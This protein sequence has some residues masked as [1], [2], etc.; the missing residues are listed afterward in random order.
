MK[1]KSGVLVVIHVIVFLVINFI[2]KYVASK[3]NLPVWLDCIGTCFTAYIYGPVC[4]GIV[5]A[6][7]SVAYGIFD[8]IALV[9]TISSILVGVLTGIMVKKGFFESFYRTCIVGAVLTSVSLIVSLPLN[10][11]F[12]HGYTSNIWGDGVCDM[13]LESGVHPFL[14]F[15]MGELVIDF[16]DKN[17]TVIFVFVVFRILNKKN[18]KK[19]EAATLI[20]A[21]LMG[22]CG[23]PSKMVYAQNTDLQRMEDGFYICSVYNE[24]NGLPGGEAN[25]VTFTIDGYVWVGTYSGLYQYDGSSFKRKESDIIKSVNCLYTDEEGRVWVGTNDRGL[26]MMVDGQVANHIDETRGLSANAISCINRD[27]KGLYYIGTKDKLNVISIVGGIEV[28]NEV[29]QVEYAYSLTSNEEG[30]TVAVTNDGNAHALWNGEYLYT[31]SSLNDKE[32]FSCAIFCDGYLYLGSYS[33]TIFQYKINKEKAEYVNRFSTKEV[34][35][36]RSIMVDEDNT[37][38]VCADNGVGFFNKAMNFVHLNT[39]SYSTSID[40]IGIDYQGNIWFT[41]SRQGLLKMSESIFANMYSKG[42][43]ETDVINCVTMWNGAF[44]IGSDNG[45]DIMTPDLML[46]T[47]NPIVE[48]LQGQRIRNLMVDSKNHLWISVSAGSGLWELSED[49][50]VNNYNEENGM[51]CNRLRSAIELEDG[52]I[53]SAHDNGITFI[54]NGQVSSTISAKDGLTAP[55]ILSLCQTKD[56]MLYAGSD[57][58]GL[59][60]IKNEKLVGKVTMNEGLSSGVILRVIEDTDGLFLVTS[61]GINYMGFDGTIKV[62]DNFP[63]SNNFDLH[64]SEDGRVWVFSSAGVFVVDYKELLSGNELSYKLLDVKSGLEGS[65]TSNSWSYITEDGLMYIPCDN[66]CYIVNTTNYMLKNVSYRMSVDYAYADE[67]R[68]DITDNR[69]IPCDGDTT[70]LTLH[71]M[72]P[73]YTTSEVYIGYQLMGFDNKETV[74]PLKELGEIKYVNLPSGTYNFVLNLYGENNLKLLEQV[75]YKVQKEMRIFDYTWFKAYFIVI[76]GFMMAW[77]TWIYVKRYNNQL[78]AK[79]REKLEQMENNARISNETIITIAKTVD[80]KDPRTSKHSER[81]AEYSA[82]IARELGWSEEECENIYKTGLL[83]DIGKIGIPDAVLNKPG[84]LTDEE[85]AIMKTHVDRG[86]EILKGFTIVKNVD[87]GTRFHH[88]RYDG[89]GYPRGLKAEEIPIQ[90]RIIGIVDAFDAMTSNRVYRQKLELS[91]VLEEMKR[92]AGT[93][94]D[95]ELT[96]VFLKLIDEGKIDVEVLY[97]HE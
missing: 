5:G 49:G 65:I 82:A 81:V 78:L 95:P 2:G 68:I 96:Q 14:S 43:Y 63:Y 90:A 32:G 9:Y 92:C 59:M 53:A 31:F 83:H 39:G 16:V 19:L 20:I 41:S 40:N 38:W 57:G 25:D 71:A 55:M 74:V 62:L 76:C 70:N 47:N 37:M 69:T 36:I 29:E 6:G 17:L 21:L 4:G 56:G 66:G 15:L 73:N 45:L 18:T 26:V 35:N 50:T 28:T 94:F 87:L 72:V 58:G 88:E 80:A 22:F 23:V 48:E 52:T 64:C 1:P 7:L 3:Y 34:R 10:F 27:N 75:S 79:E 13:L 11:I 54:K 61:N 85:Y 60:I 67:T 97:K 42:N 77:V 84:K 46:D 51:T 91:T 86:A 30:L 93:Q 89:K 8:S 12:N 33:N 24:R 44:Y